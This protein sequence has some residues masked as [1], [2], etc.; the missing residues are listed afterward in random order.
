MLISINVNSSSWSSRLGYAL[1]PS[2]TSDFPTKVEISVLTAPTALFAQSLSL[3]IQAS[4]HVE[5]DIRMMAVMTTSPMMR[6]LK[7][8]I[9]SKILSIVYNGM[10]VHS[11]ELA[12]MSWVRLFYCWILITASTVKAAHDIYVWER[13]MGSLIKILEGPKE[14]LIDVDVSLSSKVS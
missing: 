11:V 2:S 14:E 3:E 10:L 5:E 8:S 7:W 1:Q 6:L 9:N 4:A 13:A 12:T